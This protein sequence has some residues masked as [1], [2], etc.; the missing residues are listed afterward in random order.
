MK[1][2][3]GNVVTTPTT[4]PA[5][6]QDWPRRQGNDDFNRER[7]FRDF[8]RAN[9][10]CFKCGDKF[11]KEHQCKHSGQLL[12]I[13]VGEFG[14]VLSDDAVQA[15]ELLQETVVPAA[16]C[17]ISQDALAGTEGS[18]TIRLR[19]TV[20]DQVMILLIDSG[21]THTFVT[22]AFAERAGCMISPVSPLPVKIANG[23]RM[24]S[25]AQVVGLP[26]TVGETTFTT[27]MRVLELGAYDAVL[28][29]NWLKCFGAMICHWDK[30]T[31]IFEHEGRTVTL[32]GMDVPS[33]DKLA[34]F[35]MAEL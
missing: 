34:N 24:I 20:G 7:Q 30:K 6:R 27:D 26:W 13:E 33:S 22:K 10:L 18:E 25:D 5:T 15:L 8:R 28:G 4:T 31:L 12:T 17:H 23:H 32:V 16:C 35:S 1:H 19:A 2:P 9:N 14:E 29:M 3:T 21:S 11:S